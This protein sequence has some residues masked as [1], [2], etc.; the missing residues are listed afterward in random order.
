MFGYWRSAAV[1]LALFGLLA[2]APAA[3]LMADAGALRT[4]LALVDLI[5]QRRA[6]G[7]DLQDYD[8]ALGT[9]YGVLD[10]DRIVAP[11]LAAS[12]PFKF[13][14]EQDVK[15]SQAGAVVRRWLDEHPEA[16]NGSAAW[17]TLKALEAAF[18]CSDKRRP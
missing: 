9:I 7:A 14:V 15:I 10:R 3:P 1:A 5:D 6:T 18:P 13:C 11:E 17:A 16:W 4:K 2:R 8:F 12:A